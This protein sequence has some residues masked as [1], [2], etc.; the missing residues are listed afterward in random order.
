LAFIAIHSPH[1][2]H[3][4]RQL[5]HPGQP[6]RNALSRPVEPLLVPRF[7][8]TQLPRNKL[9]FDH[10]TMIR[11]P[12][13]CRVPHISHLKMWDDEARTL[14]EAPML[15]VHPP[16]EAAHTW[17][18]FFIHVGTIC[19]GLLI[20]IGLEQTV[21]LFHHRH[22]ANH[23]REMLA[24]EIKLNDQTQRTEQYVLT[25]HDAYLYNDLLV[26]GRLRNHALLPT[27]RI[28][29]F[30]PYLA[31]ADS[32]WKTAQ[33]SGAVPLLSYPEVSRF[34]EIYGLQT[35]HNT[36]SEDSLTALQNAQTLFYQGPADRF[37]DA[38]YARDIPPGAILGKEGDAMA[39]A[40][41]EEQAPGPDKLLRLT[42]AQ[43]DR[44]E[45]AIQ[46]GIYQDEKLINR[47]KWLHDA[48][49]KLSR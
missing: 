8:I 9:L 3:P 18:D 23:A 1:P 40:A 34:D 39:H 4:S 16:H 21:E 38:Q 33:E 27:D 25:L 15:D 11:Q 6:F 43:V 5:G 35:I 2:V 41:F 30:H 14:N 29:L 24:E 37:D 12:G 26:L 49:Q 17:K 36:T 44:L 45:I 42:P 20:A 47:C 46:Q 10:A 19:V 48:Y 22:E 28:V 13:G 7:L 32:A 31:F